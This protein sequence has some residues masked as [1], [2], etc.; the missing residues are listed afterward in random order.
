MDVADIAGK[1]K[2]KIVADH[3]PDEKLP[4]E[5][6]L[7]ELFGTT[8]NRVHR[9]VQQ[10][11][12]LGLLHTKAGAGT[13]VSGTAAAEDKNIFTE[14][15]Y[16]LYS[17]KINSMRL[18]LKVNIPIGDDLRFRRLWE[19]VV[20]GF[21]DEYPF[22]TVEPDFGPFEEDS[23]TDVALISTHAAYYMEP[24]L[25]PFDEALLGRH[26]FDFAQLCSGVRDAMLLGGRLMYLPIMRIPSAVLCNQTLLGRFGLSAAAMDGPRKILEASS[27]VEAGS[28]GAVHG[29]VY[30]CYHWHGCHYGVS[31]AERDGMLELDW[32]RLE[33]MLADVKAF[34][35][36][37]L[38]NRGLNLPKMFSDGKLAFIHDYRAPFGVGN[39]GQD[40][41]EVADALAPG[42]FAP[43]ATLASVVGKSCKHAEEAQLF[44]LYLASH[45]VQRR[46]AETVTG[47]KAVRKDALDPGRDAPW[48]TFDPRS[49]YSFKSRR[50]ACDFGP[51][52]NAEAAKFLLN[53]QDLDVTINN[54]KKAAGRV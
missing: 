33:G 31:I 8:Q 18:A 14:N 42:G 5:R 12:E 51:M 28:Q 2:A 38:H 39:G 15:S 16:N 29:M 35:K 19:E 34:V 46:L 11:T 45:A 25:R 47:W 40:F 48:M 37:G 7:A 24:G 36:K 53:L 17:G 52:I 44:S 6:K 32:G 26:G 43:E 13:F 49:Y 54:L 27:L 1:L 4:S 23:P 10:L 20:R 30:R 41:A 50:V 21:M 3:A 9:A 22:I